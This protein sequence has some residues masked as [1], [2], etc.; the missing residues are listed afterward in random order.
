M[1]TLVAHAT[2][3]QLSP[4]LGV[5]HVSN[6]AVWLPQQPTHPSLTCSLSG[7]SL[8]CRCRQQR[9]R[10][11]CSGCLWV[12][13]I[14][15]IELHEWD[16]LSAPAGQEAWWAQ[17]C[18]GGGIPRRHQAAQQKI[19]M[20]QARGSAANHSLTSTAHD[21]QCMVQHLG[22]TRALWVRLTAAMSGA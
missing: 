19:G 2:K 4:K 7:L 13:D 22:G 9:P 1:V 18:F 21:W 16:G 15:C 8:L 10:Q 17:S 20:V 12:S 6:A 11:L 5:G 3:L 14:C